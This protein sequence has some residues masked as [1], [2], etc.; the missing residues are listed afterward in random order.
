MTVMNSFFWIPVMRLQFSSIVCRFSAG[1]IIIRS[2]FKED[3]HSTDPSVLE[4]SNTCRLKSET[5]CDNMLLTHSFT[6][7]PPLKTG[8][9]ILNF[10]MLNYKVISSSTFFSNQPACHVRPE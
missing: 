10:G 9:M 5:D 1:I 4:L 6:Y 7:S 8:K 3:T 2:S